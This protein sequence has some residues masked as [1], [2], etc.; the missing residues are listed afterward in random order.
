MQY[1]QIAIFR[2]LLFICSPTCSQ[3][4]PAWLVTAI[5]GWLLFDC[6]R[7]STF[8]NPAASIVVCFWFFL[9]NFFLLLV[10]S[11]LHFLIAFTGG[12]HAIFFGS[13]FITAYNN[14]Y[15]YI[16]KY[17]HIYLYVCMSVYAFML[18]LCVDFP[19]LLRIFNII[20]TT[21]LLA[22]ATFSFISVHC[23]FLPPPSFCFHT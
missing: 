21:S 3:R 10:Y 12:T 15:E 23:I 14:I 18:T 7:L 22:A 16:Y 11:A 6:R 9:F 5:C 13:I 19:F 1:V 2:P 20:C 8:C 4:M 17:V